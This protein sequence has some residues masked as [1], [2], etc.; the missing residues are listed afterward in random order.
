[1][2]CIKAIGNSIFYVWNKNQVIEYD[3]LLKRKHVSY[4]MDTSVEIFNYHISDLDKIFITESNE[5]VTII[6]NNKIVLDIDDYYIFS[7]FLETYDGTYIVVSMLISGAYWI[8]SK[9][10]GYINAIDVSCKKQRKLLYIGYFVCVCDSDFRQNNEGKSMPKKAEP[11]EEGIN[12]KFA[13][14]VLGSLMYGE[15]DPFWVKN[16]D[17]VAI[18]CDHRY[19]NI[20]INVDTLIRVSVSTLEA[21]DYL[22]IPNNLL[23]QNSNHSVN[24]YDVNKMQLIKQINFEHKIIDYS[25]SLNMLVACDLHFYSITSK[26]DL[27][28]VNIGKNYIRDVNYLPQQY[29]ILM[30]IVLHSDLLFS[31]LPLEIMNIELYQEILYVKY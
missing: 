17:K 7:T 10:Y 2:D 26:L 31:Y 30:D 20:M 21:D 5:S 23:I 27:E 8:S 24:I 29:V 16:S 19:D 1:M 9:Y 6:W 14:I 13:T 18:Y 12:Q 15:S 4:Q 22:E 3:K 25:I 11:S 28:H